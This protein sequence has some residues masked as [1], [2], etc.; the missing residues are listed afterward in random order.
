MPFPLVTRSHHDETVRALKDKLTACA[1][2]LYPNGVP[3]EFQ[4]LLGIK[5]EAQTQVASEPEREPTEDERVV[6]AMKAERAR[7]EANLARIKR[8]R[9]SQL[10][11]AI[12]AMME[13]YG[14]QAASAAV[15]QSPA[16][17]IFAKAEEEALKQN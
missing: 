2:L 13:K 4:L 10:G 12:A 6:A 5:I 9:P 16:T 17:A 3:E 15:R 11:P 14:H 7:D 1:K 8:T